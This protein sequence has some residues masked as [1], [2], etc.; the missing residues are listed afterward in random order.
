[1]NRPRATPT[2]RFVLAF[3]SVAT[4]LAVSAPAEEVDFI[5]LYNGRD[6]S[7]WSGDF[8]H[9]RVEDGILVGEA[10]AERP[11]EEGSYLF[12]D[13]EFDDFELRL[14]YRILAG[15][16]GIQYRSR[17]LGAFHAAGYQA[18]LDAAS[19]VT[20]ILYETGGREVMAVRGEHAGFRAGF[21]AAFDAEEERV[22]HERFGDHAGLGVVATRGGWNRYRV[23]ARGARLVH[24]VNGRTLVIVDDHAKTAARRGRFALQLHEGAPM[25][26]EFKDVRVRRFPPGP[27]VDP[28]W[29]WVAADVK[30]GQR[31]VLARRFTLLAAPAAATLTMTCDDVFSARLNGDEVATGDD[32][33]RAV[34]RD[35][36]DLLRAGEN[37]LAVDVANHGGLAGLIGRIDVTAADGDRFTIATDATWS[38]GDAPVRTYGTGEH[39]DLGWGR[40]PLAASAD[41]STAAG[42]IA[43]PSGF[44][45]ECVRS[46]HDDDGS[47]ISLAFDSAGRAIVGDEDGRVIRIDP[48]RP[49]ERP[50][51]L[52]EFEGDAHGL[53]EAHGGLYVNVMAYDPAHGGI[54]FFRDADGDGAYD[55][56]RSIYAHHGGGEHGGH[57]LA[58]GPDGAIY[59]VHGN[60]TTR[61]A[62]R[63]AES[64]FRN[65]AEDDLLPREEDPN[66]HAEG[67]RV[68][69]GHVLRI[70]PASGRVDVIA[71]GMRNPYDL[72]F[73]ENGEL[74]TFDAD[75]EWDVGLPWYRPTRVV[76]VVSGA[77]YGW[78]SGSAKWPAHVPD[79]LP[80][81]VDVGRGSPTGVAFGTGARFPARLRSALFLGDWSLGRILAVHLEEAG[82]SF[83]GR[84]EEFATGSPL[85]VTDLAVGPDGALWFSTGGRGTQSGLYRIMWSGPFDDEAPPEPDAG[86]AAARARRHALEAFHVHAS[87]G[88]VDAAWPFLG[89]ND[90][91]LRFAAR[92]AIE[93]QM[94]GGEHGW[95]TRALLE[96]DRDVRVAA[97][98]AA[99]RVGSAAFDAIAGVLLEPAFGDLDPRQRREEVRVLTIA[100]ARGGI[101]S[102]AT[103]EALLARLGGSF[104]TGDVLLDRELFAL[105]VALD[106]PAAN[107]RGLE[108]LDAI[109][110]PIGRLHYAF[111]LRGRIDAFGADERGRFVEHVTR[112]GAADG[113]VSFDGYVDDVR[114]GLTE[115]ERART[116]VPRA[117]P[118]PPING[119]RPRTAWTVASLLPLLDATSGAPSYEGGRQAYERTLCA[120]CH[121]LGGIGGGGIAPDLTGS[122]RRFSRRDLLEAIIDPSKVV[123]DQYK[124]VELTR[125]DGSAVT[126]R[127]L[128]EDAR[129]IVVRKDPL[130]DVRV[131]VRRRD[132]ASRGPAAASPMPP[133]LLDPLAPAEIRDLLEFIEADGG[134]EDPRY[135][136]G[137]D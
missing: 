132:V 96:E 137:R 88:A 11:L 83:R 130:S 92:V 104:P 1:M 91:F 85:N 32:W 74:F 110:D 20:G 59:A 116:I 134:A 75:M 40:N 67:V 118:P 50:E 73:H 79:A 17:D 37:L 25:R 87:D 98:L 121:R 5:P 63:T 125:A 131:T 38:D 136:R 7:G 54:F 111:T 43:V 34:T 71:A 66:G 49:D 114:A 29:I 101:P 16:S 107:A 13:D 30:D 120:R 126:G 133:G 42:A 86:A 93:R 21:R 89:S 46:A 14:D 41:A 22:L 100:Y 58:L 55:E 61:P 108:R 119:V 15:N 9:W 31:G 60:M 44:A 129:E 106:D 53:L 102:E 19:V 135:R 33:T 103:R 23:I 113:G 70:D 105:L 97:L 35:V 47:W 56:R 76:H 24:E 39:P 112:L 94:P 27:S 68:P 62:E 64:P 82:A 124:D 123:S 78:R 51:T 115:A 10:T 8:D 127:I 12:H 128:S 65:E 122:A 36:T 3:L 84:V 45:V 90:P 18:D 95:T 72:A 77:E 99:A 26:V 57:G 6:L 2:A 28:E 80:A 52:L 69:G 4:S 109:D 48:A 81:V 117:D